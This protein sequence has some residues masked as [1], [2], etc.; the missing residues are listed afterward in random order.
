MVD[1]RSEWL[2]GLAGAARSAWVGVEASAIIAS[3]P[4]GVVESTGVPLSDPLAQAA[5]VAIADAGDALQ[6]STQARGDGDELADA[7]DVSHQDSTSLMTDRPAWLASIGD[8]EYL[9]SENN[10]EPTGTS[11]ASATE[12][13]D[14]G[15][16]EQSE[17]SEIDGIGAF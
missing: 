10:I 5:V 9:A 13:G 17:S 8:H 7:T 6:T 15:N 4:A 14:V 1:S 3:S 12:V 2:D 11:D 16:S